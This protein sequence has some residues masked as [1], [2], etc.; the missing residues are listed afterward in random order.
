MIRRVQAKAIVRAK[1][2][3][4]KTKPIL[5]KKEVA[6][7]LF[8]PKNSISFRTWDKRKIVIS[9]HAFRNVYSNRKET[10]PRALVPILING[11]SLFFYRSSG[12]SSHTPGVWYPTYGPNPEFN[13][14]GGK[15]VGQM[16]KTHGHW[17]YRA[18]EF[19]EWVLEISSKLKKLERQLIFHPNW[20]A[21]EFHQLYNAL[22]EKMNTELGFA[23][24]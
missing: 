15:T 5:P 21:R 4:A 6:N 3:L 18:K 10:L 22:D 20:G 2:V 9:R 7:F 1:K 14:R 13:E 8:N 23:E 11:E 19:P 24:P 16:V 12:Q 17:Q